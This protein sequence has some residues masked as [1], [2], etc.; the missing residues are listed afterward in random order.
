MNQR[1]AGILLFV[2]ALAPCDVRALYIHISDGQQVITD[3]QLEFTPEPTDQ[4]TAKLEGLVF[5][6]QNG[7]YWIDDLKLREACVKTA[8]ANGLQT[9]CSL[10][11]LTAE[12]LG[13][14][15]GVATIRF[16]DGKWRPDPL[17]VALDP[18]PTDVYIRYRPYFKV[19]YERHCCTDNCGNQFESVIPVWQ[20]AFVEKTIVPASAVP[21]EKRVPFNRSSAPCK[22]CAPSTTLTVKLD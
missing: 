1:S 3:A 7:S 6:V 14:K 13:G 18:S 22:S 5:T 12:S 10:L 4:K 11:T 20:L 2:I 9:D 17:T 8:K 16:A 21:A 15:Q 19:C